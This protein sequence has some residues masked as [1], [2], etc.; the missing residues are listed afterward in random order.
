ML[1][2]SQAT[3]CRD[4]LSTLTQHS[5]ESDAMFSQMTLGHLIEEVVQPFRAFDIEIGVTMKPGPNGK[6]QAQPVV[7]RNAGIIYGLTNLVENA[8]DYA[9]SR[10][11]ITAYWDDEVVRLTIAD[12]GPGFAPNVLG[13]LGEPFVTTRAQVED[14]DA[15]EA[16][17]MGLGIFI[18]KTLLERSNAVIMLK[19]RETP[20]SG[21]SVEVLWKKA[22]FDTA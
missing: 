19:N 18:A 15:E 7:R 4:I 13:R 3:R 2:R 10:V 11:E 5:G 9:A 8:V 20:E 22:E 21:A 12:D 14:E 1:L 17:G 16:Q 6:N